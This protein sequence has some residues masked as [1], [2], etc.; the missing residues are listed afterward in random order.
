MAELL[1]LSFDSQ[2]DADQARVIVQRV[3]GR[4]VLLLRDNATAAARVAQQ[5][6]KSMPGLRRWALLPGRAGVR[7][8][9]GALT[10]VT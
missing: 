1:I 3:A 9:R 8:L 4:D 5:R 6:A 10:A 2:I 7:A